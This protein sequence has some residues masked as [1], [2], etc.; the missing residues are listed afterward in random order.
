MPTTPFSELGSAPIAGPSPA[1]AEVRDSALFEQVEA[2]VAKLANPVNSPLLDWQ[3]VV[4]WSSELLSSK[5]KD[6]MVGCYLAGGL[7]EIK[8]LPG[9]SDGL[10][11]LE[12][13]LS[14]YWETLFPPIK[15]MRG[16]RNAMQWLIDRIQQRALDLDWASLE[17]QN[18]ETVA[19]LIS[20]VQAIDAIWLDKDPDAPSLRATL[21]LFNALPVIQPEAA[22]QAAGE[23]DTQAATST[24]TFPE[25]TSLDLA[26]RS[27]ESCFNQLQRV[28]QWLLGDDPTNPL[29]YRLNRQSAWASLVELPP[30]DNGETALPPPISQLVEALERLKTTG[31]NLELIEFAETQLPN[32]PFWLDLNFEC[33]EALAKMPETFSAARKEVCLATSG[34][35]QQLKGLEQLRFSGGMP[36]ASPDTSS[37][38]SSMAAS[39]GGGG[40]SSSALETSEHQAVMAAIGAARALASNDELMKAVHCLQEQLACTKTASSQLL[41]KIRLCELLSQHRPGA[42]IAP[43]AQGL[44]DCVRSYKLQVWEPQ[45]ALEALKTAYKVMSRNEDSKTDAESIIGLIAE[46]DL[47]EAAKLVT[48]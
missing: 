37:W 1:G 48:Q 35:S 4:D 42:T 46:I 14:T 41:L 38:L 20:A 28:A 9:L 36:F 39:S 25:I 23:K 44:L 7:L 5:G 43:F 6:V 17:P 29:A 32:F 13:M 47:S 45:L 15:R 16:R 2:E 26:A 18:P 34:F 27:I 11:V 33:A 3:K 10:K 30:S 31:S 22:P 40:S 24:E 19:R 8:G 21:A 12:G